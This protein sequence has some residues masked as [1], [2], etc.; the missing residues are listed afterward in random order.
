MF[1]PSDYRGVAVGF[2]FCSHLFCGCVDIV[3]V[4]SRDG[5]VVCSRLRVGSRLGMGGMLTLCRVVSCGVCDAA[6]LGLRGAAVVFCFVP[7]P[8]WCRLGPRLSWALRLFL[9]FFFVASAASFYVASFCFLPVSFFC[10]LF[11]LVSCLRL[12]RAGSQAM[13]CPSVLLF[14]CAHAFAL[15]GFGGRIKAG[16]VPPCPRYVG[17]RGHLGGMLS[18]DFAWARSRALR[19]LRAPFGLFA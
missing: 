3:M 13:L 4:S 18:C 19:R 6:M 5:A 17:H 8:L 14:G 2:I 7:M 9:S 10:F 1:A 11:L 15:C 12:V 16:V